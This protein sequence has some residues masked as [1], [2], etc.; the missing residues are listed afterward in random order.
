MTFKTVVGE[1]NSVQPEMVASWFETSLPTILSNYKL[2]DI[3]NADE[4]GLFYQCLPNKKFHLK[5]EKCS[6]AKNSKIRITGLAAANAVG[7][8]LPMFVIGKSK[9]P[10]CFKNVSSLPCRYRSQK[11]SWMDSALFEEWVRELDVKFE[12]QNRKIALIID[13]CP[14]HPTIA[15]LSNVKLIFLPPNTTSV[16]QPMDQGVIRCLKA[17]YRRRLVNIMIERLEKGQ[18]LPKISILRALQLLVASWNDVKESTVVNCFRKAKISAKDQENATED[19]DDPFKEL[20]KDLTELRK[21]DPTLVPQDL[22]AHEIVGVDENVI[23]TDNPQ[24]D[25]E[26]LESIRSD[27]DEE[28]IDTEI[29][30]IF[31]E[32]IDKPTKAE[33]GNALETLQNVCLFNASGDDMRQLLQ[34]FESLFVK[35]ELNAKKQTS[36]IN[37]FEKK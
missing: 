20:E 16:S 28:D 22:T 18:D 6:G 30:E 11:K 13:N 24:T 31:D 7:D 8:K 23:T 12:K 37:F 33:I 21:M 17:F 36:I 2:D 25:E 19:L 15:D 26:I 10:R 4:F 32:P 29:V 14:A 9:T 35:D 1:S 27:K 3:F 34:R 5:S